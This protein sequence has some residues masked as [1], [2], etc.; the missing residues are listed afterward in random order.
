MAAPPKSALAP[1]P[2]PAAA[3]PEEIAHVKLLDEAIAPVRDAPLSADDA[4]RIRDAIR[5][6]GAGKVPD[7][8][9]LKSEISDPIGRKLVEWYRLRSGYGD[10]PEYR[11]FLDQNPAWPDRNLMTQRLEEALFTQGG[12]AAAIKAAFKDN[13]PRTGIGMAALASALLAEGDTESARKL[14]AKAWREESIPSSLETGFLD[15]FKPLLTAADHKWR[16]DRLLLD[17][18]R[19]KNERGDRASVARRV[20]A[21]LPEADH[22]KANARLAVFQKSS[23]AQALMEAAAGDAASDWGFLFHRIQQLRLSKRTDD[24]AKLMLTAP[25]DPAKTVS[26]DGWWFERRANAYIAL[27]AGKTKLAYDLIKDAGPLSVNPAKE[28][29]FM[30]GWIA[31]R[32]LKDPKAAEAHFNAMRKAADGPLSRAKALYWLA[33]IA[34][35]RGE[36]ARA[37]EY[38][39]EAAIDGDTFHG[40][41]ARLK[42]DPSNRTIVIK[43]PQP[44]TR[45]E[46]DAFNKLDAVRATVIARRSS[47]DTSVVRAFL[48]QL[49]NVK[50]NELP[51][52]TDCAF[53]GCA[54]RDA[55]GTAH[56]QDGHRKTSEPSLLLL[57]NPSI[58][59][60]HASARAA[61]ARISA[62]HRAS[63][64]RVQQVDRVRR[65]GQRPA[66]G[67]DGDCGAHLPR[68]SGQVRDTA[69][70]HR[71]VVQHHDCF[72]LHR[73]PHGRVRRLLR[74]DPR[75]L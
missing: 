18:L 11:A 12:S 7:G 21:L 49:R 34:E 15:R 19:Y 71:H 38:Y 75:R 74:A 45:E 43:P 68:L 46:I 42:I 40:L 65:R 9:S 22:K 56:R 73:G 29:A 26:P 33:R 13:P 55:D 64:D 28:Q 3:T 44:P 20:I 39:K 54:G 24:A 59:R 31:L 30:A 6:I 69:T 63:G 60:L 2:K 61:R 51:G 50:E 67:D 72:G 52:R 17:D 4:T 16:L 23:G 70:A 66:A 58:P 47:L 41:L 62:G 8:Q 1:I 36:Q 14:A 10:A 37:R 53:G 32:L 57:P 35:S 25:T 5:A 27:N 48:Y